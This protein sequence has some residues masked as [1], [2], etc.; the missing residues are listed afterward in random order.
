MSKVFTDFN[1]FENLWDENDSSLRKEWE[2][3]IN[4]LINDQVASDNV[5]TL[6]IKTSQFCKQKS[7]L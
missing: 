1:G 6:I 3:E 7:Q 4:E 2:E 5:S